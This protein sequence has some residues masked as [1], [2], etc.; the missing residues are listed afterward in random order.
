[1]KLSPLSVAVS[2][3]LFSHICFAESGTVSNQNEQEFVETV[4]VTAN[5]IDTPLFEVP[6][7][8]SVVD[9]DKVEKE[10][11]TEL[12]DALDTEPGVSVTGGAGRSQNI[13]IRG[14]TGN[15]VAIVKDGVK[16]S[17]GYGALDLNDGAGR[18]TFDI[19]SLKQIEV[20]K[21]ASSNIHG[22]GAIGGVVVLVSKK[23]EDYL[24]GKDFHSE[25]G[26]T[27]TQISNK[28]KS[29]AL[30]AFRFQDTEALIRASYW[31]GEETRNYKQD[32]YN[33]DIDG[34]N[35]DAVVDH[36][37]HDDFIIKAKANYYLNRVNRDEGT[38]IVQ[39]DGKWDVSHYNDKVFTRTIGVEL[40]TQ[41]TVSNAFYDELNTKGYLRDSTSQRDRNYSI[42]RDNRG[43]TEYRN[44]DD[45]REFNDSAMGINL[46][47]NKLTDFADMQHQIVYGVEVDRR[48]YN[49]PVSRKTFDTN[50]LDEQDKSP[51]AGVVTHRFSSYIKDRATHGNWIFDLGARFDFHHLEPET[52]SEI[53]G[54]EISNTRSSEWSPSLSVTHKFTPSLNGYISYNHG[55]RAPSYDKV[56]GFVPHLFNLFDPFYIIPNLELEKE[57]SDSYEL[58]AKYQDGQWSWSTAVFHTQYKNF[59]DVKRIGRDPNGNSLYQYVNKKNVFTQG[60][61][62]SVAYQIDEQWAVSTKAGV[63]DG[64]DGDGNYIRSLTP[65]EGNVQLDYEQNA[66]SGY[67]RMNWAAEMTRT[68]VCNNQLQVE[69]PCDQTQAWQSL[70][71]GASVVLWDDLTL[72]A[73]VINLLDNQFTRYQDI[74]GLGKHQT[75]FSTE[76]GRYFTLNAKYEF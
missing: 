17:D 67:L 11:A 63:V 33:R 12:Y 32:L 66:L 56:Y 41:H 76:P 31:L 75:S 74:A 40:G 45:H 38:H 51:F 37:L 39:P 35:L 2:A 18:D 26:T 20:V 54:Y 52:R 21:G 70:D 69:V 72:S 49:R 6:G 10:G 34:Y 8:I 60:M 14:M 64:K 65:W 15:R 71:A 19:N 30:S 9:M 5:K 55:Y 50:G 44:E 43:I 1:M 4:V 16:M 62:F 58:G 25:V 59:I 13:V 36:Y 61:E 23:P 47:A 28:T 68:P 73:N 57:T 27:Y 7:S 42:Y 48:S 53:G 3:A 29:Y 22:S 24:Q 46:D